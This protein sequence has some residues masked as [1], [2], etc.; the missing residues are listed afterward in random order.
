M[1]AT[2]ACDSCSFF[3]ASASLRLRA[4]SGFTTSSWSCASCSSRAPPP[5]S[6]P[7]SIAPSSSS[8]CGASSRDAEMIVSPVQLMICS[9]CFLEKNLA[10]PSRASA[11]S[12]VS[13]CMASERAA[14]NFFRLNIRKT[15]QLSSVAL[16]FVITGISCS[17]L[18]TDETS[19]SSSAAAATPSLDFT[20][21][22]VVAL[23]APAP[24]QPS[25]K[26]Q[27]PSPVVSTLST[28]S[29]G[30]DTII[31]SWYSLCSF[32]VKASKM[33]FAPSVSMASA[34]EGSSLGN[35]A[36]RDCCRITRTS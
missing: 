10:A 5:R 13:D 22:L 28:L 25:S 1:R 16:L 21:A 32:L 18:V 30:A 14:R 8:S 35:V 20:A 33:A 12:S 34:W 15:R 9:S 36:T 4:A 26:R 23:G 3:T 7:P 2:F 11:N 17:A 31:S 27:G 24:S 6:S 29:A 19:G